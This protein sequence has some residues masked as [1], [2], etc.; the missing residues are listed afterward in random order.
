MSISVKSMLVMLMKEFL[1]KTENNY[2]NVN[3]L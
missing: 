3:K 2:K 1:V